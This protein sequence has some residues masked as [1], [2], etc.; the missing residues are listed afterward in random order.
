MNIDVTVNQD[1]STIIVKNDGNG[2]NTG[3]IM[4]EGKSIPNP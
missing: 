2:L 3:N 4:C 1:T